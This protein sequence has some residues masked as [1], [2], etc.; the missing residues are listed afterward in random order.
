M[1]IY[2]I[3]EDKTYDTFNEVI[4]WS[5]NYCVYKAGKGTCKIYAGEDE[6][7]TDV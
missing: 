1:T 2:L 5:D 4:E 6:Y 3:K 7:F